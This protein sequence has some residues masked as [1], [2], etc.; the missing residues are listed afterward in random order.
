[1]DIFRYDDFR[2]FLRDC[3]ERKKKEDSSFSHRQFALLAGIKNPGYL[4]DVIKGKRRLSERVL[5]EAIKIFAIKPSHADFFRALV[6]YGQARKPAERQ[7]LYKELLNRRAHS[8]FVRLN[9]AQVKYYEDTAY[10]LLIAAVETTDFRGDYEKLAAFLDPPMQT[11]KVKKCI[12]E[13]CQWNMIR[14]RADGRYIIVERFL[15]PPKTLRG[16]VRRINGAWFDEAREALVRFGPDKRHVSTLLLSISEE[17][18]DQIMERIESFRRDILDIVNRDGD[19]QVVMQL[20]TAFFP[21]SK[22]TR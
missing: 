9:S 3:F 2:Q 18:R 7:A 17:A 6:A 22:D 12:R 19:A 13:L 4:L 20:S 16:P 1:M 8:N 21:K 5:E 15:E 10:P 14:Q 11:G